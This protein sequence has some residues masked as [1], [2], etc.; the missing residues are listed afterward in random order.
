[1][2]REVTRRHLL[3]GGAVSALAALAGCSATTPFVGVRRTE[4][5]RIE[6]RDATT[7]RIA[8]DVGDVTVRG[9]DRDDVRAD[10]VKQ[11]SSVRGDVSDLELVTER[12][13]DTLRLRSE[14]HDSPPL[15]GS[16]PSL[17]MDLVVPR[18]LRVAAITTTT[19]D[20]DVADVGGDLRADTNTGD[21][22]AARVTGTVT[23]EANTGDITVRDPDALGD[24][25]TN[26]G[27]VSADAPAIDGA[28]AVTANTGDIDVF[29]ADSLDADV[30]A[31]TDTGDISVAD[32]SLSEVTREDEV[33][34]GTLSGTL[35]DGG[36]R[37][38]L[39]ASTG[40]ISIQ[41]L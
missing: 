14:G 23:A 15:L 38:R 1:M 13:D 32:V 12:T 37:L 7:L 20:V 5:R 39:E 31:E 17:D 2:T 36:P 8:G 27:D 21:V 4:T 24:V 16:P 35:G 28:T 30:Q 19:G 6:P 40:D 3:S 26:T 11:S 18:S 34:G 25:G 22:T 33:S 10:I 41:P 29:V 9:E